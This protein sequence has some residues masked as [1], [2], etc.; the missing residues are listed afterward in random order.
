MIQDVRSSSVVENENPAPLP[1]GDEMMLV[2]H[3]AKPPTGVSRS[4]T[5][6]LLEGRGCAFLV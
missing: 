4:G 2:S 5:R 3:R 1:A 6:D